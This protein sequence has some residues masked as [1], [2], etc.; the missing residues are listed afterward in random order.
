VT[1]GDEGRPPGKIGHWRGPGWRFPLLFGLSIGLGYGALGQAVHGLLDHQRWN[2]ADMAVS[3]GL[4][5]VICTPTWW[6]SHR[7]ARRAVDRG[8]LSPSPARRARDEQVGLV[9]PAID[10]GALPRDADPDVWRPALRGVARELNG[11]RWTAGG[12]LA[13]AALIG[14]A[15]AVGNHN[16]WPVWA[17]AVLFAAEGVAA[18]RWLGRRRHVVRRL[19]AETG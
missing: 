5:A 11:L 10:A 2:W 19:L 3:G 4:W 18:F 12:L 14:A 8:W 13:L 7:A 1:P 6:L 15:A 17:V 16:A 9:K